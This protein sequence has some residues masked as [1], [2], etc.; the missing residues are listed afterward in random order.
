MKNIYIAFSIISSRLDITVAFEGVSED[1]GY[2]VKVIYTDP[3]NSPQLI[4]VDKNGNKYI[5]DGTAYVD[6]KTGINYILINSESPANRTKAGVIGTI[7]EEQSHIIGKIEG[8]QKV[9]PDGSEKGL[10]SLG[11]PT[12][13]YFKNEFSKND[14]AIGIVSD[15]KDYSNVDFGENVGDDLDYFEKNQY[16]N[17]KGYMKDDGSFKVVV[18]PKKGESELEAITNGHYKIKKTDDFLYAQEGNNQQIIDELSKEAKIKSIIDPYNNYIVTVSREE[19]I[20][21]LAVP[22]AKSWKE[23]QSKDFHE[24]V[25]N[26]AKSN[27]KVAENWKNKKYLSAAGNGIISVLNVPNLI[28]TGAGSTT[29]DLVY[30]FNPGEVQFGKRKDILERRGANKAKAKGT[31]D[32]LVSLVGS[33]FIPDKIGGGTI[34]I[35]ETAQ[36]VVATGEVAGTTA[37]VI[38]LSFQGI[39]M[40]GF[41]AALMVSGVGNGSNN[42]AKVRNDI[43]NYKGAEK[44]T[45]ATKTKKD[46]ARE[47]KANE[48][49]QNGKTKEAE[50]LKEMVWKTDSKKLDEELLKAGVVKPD[51]KCAAHHIVTDKMDDVVKILKDNDIDINSAANGVYL[52]TKGAKLSEVGKEAIHIGA[53]SKEYRD[54]ITE[55]IIK[56]VEKANNNNLSKSATKDAILKEIDNIRNDLLTGKLKINNAKLKS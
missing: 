28:Q 5:K 25:G 6:K 24:A 12:N 29:A 1:L 8:R 13:D 37:G 7:A 23:N 26:I 41:K 9:V 52:P 19:G 55:R 42:S 34:T 51:Y 53:T 16:Y 54:K 50:K 45:T 14:K 11:K 40:G 49:I 38:S 33:S 31:T 15:G 20:N 30:S 44:Q 35:P 2:K 4:G 36:A 17:T 18:T 56:V 47:Q 22:K 3:S 27:K 39:K 48:L 21:I 43:D 32:S 46:L 10:E